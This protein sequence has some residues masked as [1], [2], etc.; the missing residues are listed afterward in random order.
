MA[1]KTISV[2]AIF[3]KL[4]TPRHILRA[5]ALAFYRL[6]P[7]ASMLNPVMFMVWMGAVVVTVLTAY[8]LAFLGLGE[9][10]PSDRIFCISLTVWLWFTLWTANFSE[11]LAEERGQA[12]AVALRGTR[13]KILAKRIRSVAEAA[14]PE[15]VLS[16]NLR[17]GDLLLIEP[18]DIIAA[19]AEVV[20]GVASVDE[21]AVTGESAPVIRQPGGPDALL[22]GGTRVLSDRLIA[23]VRSEPGD[24][25]LDKMIS[26]VDGAR[27]R[28]TPNEVALTIMLTAITVVLLLSCA[29]IVPFSFYA[30]E[31]SLRGAPVHVITAAAFLVCVIP[32]T[33]AGLLS[34]IGIA[35]MSKMMK[36]NVIAM[37]GRAVEAAG[38]VDV[39]ILDKTGTIT[40][41]NRQAIA[42]VPLRNVTVSELAN[43]AAAASI[44]DET[45]EGYS[46]TRLARERYGISTDINSYKGAKFIAFSAHT[47]MSGI[48]FGG[49]QIRKGAMSAIAGWMKDQGA[50]MPPEAE[51][52]AV[53]MARWGSTPLIVAENGRVLGMVELK[54][55]VKTGIKERFNRLRQMGIRTVMLTGDNKYTAAAIAA[56]A[57]IDDYVGEVDPEDKLKIVRRLQAEGKRVAMTGDGTNDAPALAK[58]DVAVAMGNGTQA[59]K[60]A[61]NMVDLDSNP[62]KLLDIIGIGKQILLTRGALTT[63]SICND[64]AKYFSIIPAAFATTYPELSVLNV[65]HLSSP[66]SAVLSTVIF[67]AVIIFIVMPV[68]LHGVRFQGISPMR[69]LRRNLIIYGGGGLVIPFALIKAIDVAL[70]YLGV[71]S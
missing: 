60:E 21:S 49:R 14:S 50:A 12:T 7:V 43:A 39:L 58:A 29:T 8:S 45:P 18:G 56:E 13:R 22:V 66:E 59:A 9:T 44:A 1:K 62:T 28:R 23:R 10:R 6:N 69:L 11:A 3:Q 31:T 34:T 61:G 51:Q 17:K 41:G 5:A 65:M 37:S 32:T 40:V 55:V 47:R 54:D 52:K 35:G 30:A 48:D 46:I 38:D 24:S 19:D 64:I 57:G 25:F 63:F 68:A 42:F 71:F 67:N 4:F 27:R 33:I 20:D 53:S 16:E 2:P 26:M 70:G 36:A 15:L